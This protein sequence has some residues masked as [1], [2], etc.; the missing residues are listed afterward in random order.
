MLAARLLARSVSIALLA[1]A[2][3]GSAVHVVRAEILT[4]DYAR[5]GIKIGMDRSPDE[6]IC[7]VV[8]IS[9][10]PV[11]EGTGDEKVCSVRARVL[12]PI[13]AEGIIAASAQKDAEFDLRSSKSAVGTIVVVFA[14]PM[15][16]H[17]QIYYATMMGTRPRVTEVDNIK[18][19]YQKLTGTWVDPATGTPGTSSMQTPQEPA[20]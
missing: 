7:A 10:E 16:S 8:R 12:E 15:K 11:C 17:P 5:D 18:A 6:Y 20:K 13:G 4:E 14:V 19:A 1:L 9:T 2:C 3:A